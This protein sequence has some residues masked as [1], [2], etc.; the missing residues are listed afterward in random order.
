MSA[1]EEDMGQF[2]DNRGLFFAANFPDQ[3]ITMGSQ[4]TIQTGII[5]T[6]A[7]PYGA[8]SGPA[9]MPVSNLAVTVT[10]ESPDGWTSTTDPSQHYFDG[11]VSFSSTD[12]GS[13]RRARAP[14]SQTPY[15][16][17]RGFRDSQSSLVRARPRLLNSPAPCRNSPPSMRMT[18]PLR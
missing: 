12:A 14:A 13:L 10:A 6:T 7:T 15:D 17:L 1:V 8:T 3:P 18:S 2:A 11:T 9:M 5:V 16:F 4:F